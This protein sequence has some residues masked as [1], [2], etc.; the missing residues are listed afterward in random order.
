MIALFCVLIIVTLNSTS[1]AQQ[2]KS[3]GVVI[4]GDSQ[5][6]LWSIEPPKMY[7]EKAISNKNMFMFDSFKKFTCNRNLI[8]DCWC[9]YRESTF[10]NIEH[11]FSC[12]LKKDDLRVL[13]ISKK[14]S[15]LLKYVSLFSNVE[16]I[17]FHYKPGD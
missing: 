3:F 9:S 8:P 14:C 5:S 17:M 12:C 4:N 10:A 13:E 16:R 7:G 11:S 15:I 2:I 6:R 1:E